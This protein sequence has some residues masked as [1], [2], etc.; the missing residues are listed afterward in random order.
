LLKFIPIE[1]KS[2]DECDFLVIQFAVIKDVVKVFAIFVHVTL[3]NECV[4]HDS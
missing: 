2:M 4:V 1:G 3:S